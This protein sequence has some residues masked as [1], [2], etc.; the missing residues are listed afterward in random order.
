M[1]LVLAAFAIGLTAAFAAEAK[2]PTFIASLNEFLGLE[3]IENAAFQPFF[4]TVAW[5]ETGSSTVWYTGANWTPDTTAVQWT[6]T[7]VAQFNNAGSAVTTGINMGTLP[8]SI[9]AIEMTSLRT[10][11]L[12]IGNSSTN[13]GT[14]TLN[15]ATLNGQSNVILRNAANFMLT[16]QNSEIGSGRTMNVAL[17]NPTDNLI[18][19]EGGGDIVIS[20][21]ISGAGK[22]LTVAGSGTHALK[23]TATNTYSGTMTIKSGGIIDLAATGSLANSP[24]IEI[25][26]GGTLD[27]QSL[28]TPFVLEPAQALKA[29]GIGSIV[30]D[31]IAIT[32]GNNAAERADS[33]FVHGNRAIAHYHKTIADGH[34]AIAQAYRGL[35][36]NRHEIA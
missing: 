22:N 23:L 5:T 8:L 10:R 27:V 24:L 35:T 19:T 1:Q 21:V 6:T 7:D 16:L 3:P 34:N 13:A 11:E 32:L 18:L 4:T 25:Q 9:G 30:A 20:S 31:H 15:G 28:A 17:G 33:G 36:R 2:A 29:S 26:G 12:A 14:L